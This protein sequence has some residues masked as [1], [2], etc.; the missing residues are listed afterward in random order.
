MSGSGRQAPVGHPVKPGGAHLGGSPRVVAGLIRPDRLVVKILDIHG[1]ETPTQPVTRRR[2]IAG[3]DRTPAFP[4]NRRSRAENDD[5][6]TKA[7]AAV[8]TGKTR[9]QRS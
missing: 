6:G 3:Q 5:P 8:Y 4:D 9:K 7:G 2:G 1:P